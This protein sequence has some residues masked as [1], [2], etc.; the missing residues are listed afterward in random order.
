MKERSSVFFFFQILCY[1]LI[2]LEAEPE[3]LLQGTMVC[4]CTKLLTVILNYFWRDE[5]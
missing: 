5:F 2:M 1:S 3:K 4:C